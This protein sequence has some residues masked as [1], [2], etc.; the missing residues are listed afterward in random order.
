MN[1]LCFCFRKKNWFFLK[2]INKRIWKKL[3]KHIIH[4][5]ES[6][7]TCLLVQVPVNAPTTPTTTTFRFLNLSDMF[8]GVPETSRNAGNE[9]TFAPVANFLS[10]PNAVSREG[11]ATYLNIFE[12]FL[13]FFVKLC[14]FDFFFGQIFALLFVNWHGCVRCSTTMSTIKQTISCTSWQHSQSLE[15][16]K[17]FI[18][19]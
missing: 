12:N 8:S 5:L 11:F 2:K 18:S 6:Y 17:N 7:G 15:N 19:Q 14:V 9:T 1:N 10:E 3:K 16:G 13:L 4:N